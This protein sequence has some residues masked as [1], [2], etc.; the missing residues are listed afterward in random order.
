MTKRELKKYGLTQKAAKG[1]ATEIVMTMM[2]YPRII[3]NVYTKKYGHF[4]VVISIGD[5]V[6]A[7]QSSMKLSK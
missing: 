7:I 3:S 5:V 4:K 1:L 6:K 2:P